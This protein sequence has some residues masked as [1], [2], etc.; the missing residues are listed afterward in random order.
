[1]KMLGSRCDWPFGDEMD[2]VKGG[3][4][5]CEVIESTWSRRRVRGSECE[6]KQ[7]IRIRSVDF[8]TMIMAKW[9]YMRAAQKATTDCTQAHKVV[10]QHA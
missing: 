9:A 7:I 10:E 1:M 6:K 3:H 8:Y 2:Y 4:A 5:Q